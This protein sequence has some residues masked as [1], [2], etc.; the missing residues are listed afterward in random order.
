MVRSL[1]ERE[2][3]TPPCHRAHTLRVRS[4]LYCAIYV[5]PARRYTSR[6]RCTK[7]RGS[8]V[9]SPNRSTRPRPPLFGRI[10]TPL[11]FS[12]LALARRTALYYFYLL[13][14]P[15]FFF[16][17]SSFHWHVRAS[18]KLHRVVYSSLKRLRTLRNFVALDCHTRLTNHRSA[19]R[20]DR[21]H[22]PTIGDGCETF[23]G[24]ADTHL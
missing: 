22:W 9:R 16:I 13:F 18:L 6:K 24:V 15:R 5:S 12:F 4:V 21:C 20:N 11:N 8:S 2:F 14:F 3:T 19:G 17:R 7:D 1:D 23:V 10:V